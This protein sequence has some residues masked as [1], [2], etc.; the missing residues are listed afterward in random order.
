MVYYSSKYARKQRKEREKMIEKAKDLIENPAKYTR[1]TSYG[2]ANYV[3]NID[4]DRETG[5]VK[6]G[7]TLSLDLDIQRTIKN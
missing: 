7:K 4:Y 6:T 2:A 1:A 5:E 3:N